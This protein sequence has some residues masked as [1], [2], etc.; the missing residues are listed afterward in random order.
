M[1]CAKCGVKNTEDSKF[2]VRCGTPFVVEGTAQA[3][4]PAV[5]CPKCKSEKLQT[6]TE[7]GNRRKFRCLECGFGF[8][9]YENMISE[10][11]KK[12]KAVIM[13]GI[14]LFT[15][16]IWILS[17]SFNLRFMICMLVL[18]LACA[19]GYMQAKEE[20]DDLVQKGF[21]ADCYLEKK[22]QKES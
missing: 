12:M 18:L 10:R 5:H 21:D 19:G 22:K 1:F 20:C 15:F 11:K 9:H 4:R 3:E 16:S 17:A 7:S 6:I 2:C 13:I 8:G 14:A